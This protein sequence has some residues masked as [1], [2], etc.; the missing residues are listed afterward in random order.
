MAAAEEAEVDM[1]VEG[2]VAVEVA[3]AVAVDIAALTRHLWGE[4]DAGRNLTRCPNL[5]TID[6]FRELRSMGI[7]GVGIRFLSALPPRSTWICWSS[8]RLDK[9]SMA[10]SIDFS[11]T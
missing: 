10:F 2:V 3:V 11:R 4:I 9:E 8:S 5:S 1:A 6:S 7:K